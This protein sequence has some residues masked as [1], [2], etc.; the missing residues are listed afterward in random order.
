[1]KFNHNE[2]VK[3]YVNRDEDMKLNKVQLLQHHIKKLGY[4]Y[5]DI[6]DQL[7]QCIKYN[8]K[9]NINNLENVSYNDY[10]LTFSKTDDYYRIRYNIINKAQR[11]IILSKF[12]G[13][14]LNEEFYMKC[15]V[16]ELEF[17]GF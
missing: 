3:L 17:L 13:T 1:M 10:K 2:L 9:M 6:K 15:T 12:S 14:S 4:N 11:S 8:Y 7:E 5:I 16:E